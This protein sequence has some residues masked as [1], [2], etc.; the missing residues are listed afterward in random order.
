[1]PRPLFGPLSALSVLF[2][3]TAISA[4]TGCGTHDSTAPLMPMATPPIADVPV[5]IGFDMVTDQSV[6]RV[7]PNGLR[8]VDHQYKGGD[9]QMQVV[10][11]YKT[12]LPQQGWSMVTQDQVH[13]EITLKYAKNDEDL[14]ITIKSGNLDTHVRVKIDPSARNTTGG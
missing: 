4:L 8:F 10:D 1:M 2:A 5:P 11:F 7:L 9:S 3:V 12:N 14:L 6:S 13:D